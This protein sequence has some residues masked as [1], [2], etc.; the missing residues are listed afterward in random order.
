MT[1]LLLIDPTGESIRAGLS[2]I[3]SILGSQIVRSRIKDLRSLCFL[4]ET[5]ARFGSRLVH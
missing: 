3:K 4:H 5:Y 2:I 1:S